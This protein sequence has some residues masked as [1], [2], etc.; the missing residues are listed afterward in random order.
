M[1]LPLDCM[2]SLEECGLV[3]QQTGR[4]KAEFVDGGRAVK[5]SLPGWAKQSDLARYMSIYARV[6]LAQT[7]TYIKKPRLDICAG[8]G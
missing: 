6:W 7:G 1:D 5:L 4:G 3:L 2:E 8:V